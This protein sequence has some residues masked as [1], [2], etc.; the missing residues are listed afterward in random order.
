MMMNSHLVYATTRDK[1]DQ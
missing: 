1:V